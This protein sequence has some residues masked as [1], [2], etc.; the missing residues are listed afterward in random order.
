MKTPQDIDRT[1]ALWTL[2]LILREE[3][4][5]AAARAIVE[6]NRSSLD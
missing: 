4:P 5:S 3:L 2:G 1:E 6:G